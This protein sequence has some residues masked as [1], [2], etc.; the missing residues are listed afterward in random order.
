MHAVYF[1]R[2][3]IFYAGYASAVLIF[4]GIGCLVA[5]WLTLRRRYWFLTRFNYFVL[6]WSR[7][8]C[9]IRY[10]L[11]GAEHIPA[12]PC[13]VLSNHESAWETYYLATLFVPQ[14]TVLKKELLSIP[15]FGWALRRLHPIAIDRQRPTHALK[16]LVQQG[17]T[18]LENGSWVMIFPEGT[19]VRPGKT[20]KF[21][22]GGALLAHQAGVPIL[23][24]A[25]T[26]GV[27]WP[28][29]S[30]TKY[31]GLIRVRIGPLITGEGL[32]R[33]EMHERA[34]QWIR[35]AMAELK[36]DSQG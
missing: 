25:H 13:V 6:W 27:C 15:V 16:Q 7:V 5:P 36:Q 31:P 9:G 8:A 10:Q 34:E 32:S 20:A 11:E 12:Q 35:T 19:R 14:S 18:R 17:K 3:L 21:N 28:A 33:D 23:P 4:G 2:S 1:L 30:V 29:G 24:V 22:K 26:A